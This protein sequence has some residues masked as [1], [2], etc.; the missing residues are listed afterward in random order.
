MNRTVFQD[1]QLSLG[2]MLPLRAAE[3][4]VDFIG[5]I[6]FAVKAEALGFDA[7]WVRDVPL[8]GPWYP[9]TFGHLDPFAML[10]AI[11][12]RTQR[13]TLGTAAAVLP[14]RH[15]LHLAKSAISIDRLSQGR[16]ILG[17]GSG[18]RREEFAAFGADT[19]DHKELYRG[20]W[21]QLSAALER[22]AR[23]LSNTETAFELWPSAE[24]DIPRLAIG[25]GGQTLEWI[26]RNAAGWVTYHRP[27]IQQKDRYALWRNAVDRVTPGS[28]RSF[29]VALHLH[30]EEDPD[31]PITEIN[32][33][34][35]TGSRGL[36]TLLEEMRSDGT[37]HVILALDP[38]GMPVDRSLEIIAASV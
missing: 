10:G 26:A 27:R 20:H 2:L 11:A 37:H 35:R 38:N 14:L 36:A 1:N 34:Y 4:D 25:S 15:P 7:L 24:S 23:V 13:I 31:A 28:F 22:P 6:D 3:G 18:D 21:T 17:L 32:L 33:G 9:E 5:Q 30:L 29:S 19:G 16:F 8:N 12:A